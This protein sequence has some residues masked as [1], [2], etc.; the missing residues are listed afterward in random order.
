MMSQVE[1]IPLDW[2]MT[3]FHE[4]LKN[5]RVARKLTQTRVAEL[6][7]ISPRVYHR[8]EA[9]GAVPPPLRISQR[10]AADERYDSV[11]PRIRIFGVTAVP[12]GVV[13][14]ARSLAKIAALKQLE[15]F[16]I[17]QLSTQNSSGV[18]QRRLDFPSLLDLLGVG[19]DVLS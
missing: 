7:G 5:L 14:A 6:L 4:R 12:T 9:G 2:N 16:L 11:N 19:R 15:R 8:W 10:A 18:A 13:P 17:E 1:R 3:D